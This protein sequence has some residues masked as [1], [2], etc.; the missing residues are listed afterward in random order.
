[1]ATSEFYANSSGEII[2]MTD[3]AANRDQNRDRD[4]PEGSNSLLVA[5][6][7]RLFACPAKRPGS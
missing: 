7:H 3:A 5:A 6:L 4:S 2:S 1:M